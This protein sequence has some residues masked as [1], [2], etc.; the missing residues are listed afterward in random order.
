MFECENSAC[1]RKLSVD[2]I[3]VVTTF[4]VRRFCTMEC[5]VEGFQ[6]H[7]AALLREVDL[8]AQA[9]RDSRRPIERWDAPFPPL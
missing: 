4:H 7:R 6:N 9:E 3:T 8:A 1:G 2:H 5:V